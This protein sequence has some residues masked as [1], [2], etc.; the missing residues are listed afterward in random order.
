M[1]EDKQQICDLFLKA[2]QAT[3]HFSDLKDLVYAPGADGQELVIATFDGGAHKFAN[4]TADSGVAVLK[5]IL[6]Q[7][8]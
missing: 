3:A 7:M 8:M 1:R 2:L 6:K 5:D 4:V